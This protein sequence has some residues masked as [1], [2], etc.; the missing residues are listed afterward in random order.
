M[1]QE[2]GEP[3]VPNSRVARR[4][5]S[6]TATPGPPAMS[7]EEEEEEARSVRRRARERKEDCQLQEETSHPAISAHRW[8][9]ETCRCS[10]WPPVQS[11]E[12]RKSLISTTSGQMSWVCV[13]V[14]SQDQR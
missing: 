4:R 13:S 14:S 10:S 5:P 7:W 1:Q 2:S 11:S 3:W 12:V 9:S 8:T 6:Y